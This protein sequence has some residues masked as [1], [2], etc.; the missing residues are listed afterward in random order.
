M[1]HFGIG[2]AVQAS[3]TTLFQACRRTGRTTSLIE[4]LRD[5]DRVIACNDQH[6]RYLRGLLA[7]RNLKVEVLVIQPKD[8]HMLWEHPTSE[9]RT[10]FDHPW[11]EQFY[12]QAFED[13]QK[14]VDHM[15]RESSGFGT[16]HYETQAK[17]RQFE[18][19]WGGALRHILKVTT[20]PKGK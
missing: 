1:D 19:T 8:H 7:Q 12:Q 2:N 14:H 15:Q 18:D 20:P 10:L 3:L 6:A 17:A 5:G 13:A 16:A 4:S 11:I 9:G